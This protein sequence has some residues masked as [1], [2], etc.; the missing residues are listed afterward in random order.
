MC[1]GK[2]LS[3]VARGS[4]SDCMCVHI[5]LQIQTSLLFPSAVNFP[6]TVLLTCYKIQGLAAA[7]LQ[8]WTFFTT[9]NPNLHLPSSASDSPGNRVTIITPRIT[10]TSNI[11]KPSATWLRPSIDGLCSFTLCQEQSCIITNAVSHRAAPDLLGQGSC[12]WR[13]GSGQDGSFEGRWAEQALTLWLQSYVCRFL[14]Q[15]SLN[16]FEEDVRNTAQ[17]HTALQWK[18]ESTLCSCQ[19]LVGSMVIAL[20]PHKN[21]LQFCKRPKTEAALGLT[22][23]SPYREH[24]YRPVLCM[25]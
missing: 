15:D 14:C 23:P 16:F 3:L 8:V 9:N 24:L 1:F 18:T 12:M 25:A 10:M 5:S 4:C 13:C 6:Q 2:S 7:K 19:L 11:S 20:P 22:L 21:P 17:L